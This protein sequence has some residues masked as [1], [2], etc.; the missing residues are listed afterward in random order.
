MLAKTSLIKEP[1]EKVLVFNNYR[2]EAELKKKEA[3]SS[4]MRGCVSQL[5]IGGIEY[6]EAMYLMNKEA[7]NNES[8]TED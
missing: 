7:K 1:V 3:L 8:E 6:S 2:P 5:L 4:L